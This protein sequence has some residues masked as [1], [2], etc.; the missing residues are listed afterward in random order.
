[1]AFFLLSSPDLGSRLGIGVPQAAAAREKQAWP[2]R[3][4]GISGGPGF[5]TLL[6][7][8]PAKCRLMIRVGPP[9]CNARR[10]AH[11]A[12]VVGG[13]KLHSRKS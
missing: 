1:M 7:Y 8:L 5:G 3:L 4:Y 2:E 10:P 13:R 12:P 6:L 9:K 11:M